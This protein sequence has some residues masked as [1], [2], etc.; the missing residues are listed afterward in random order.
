MEAQIQLQHYHQIQTFNTR[1]LNLPRHTKPRTS[2]TFSFSF[3]GLS[4]RLPE[5]VAP[6]ATSKRALESKLVI[7]EGTEEDWEMDAK[8][9]IELGF[10]EKLCGEKKGIAE[11]M[12]CLEEEAIFGSDQGRAPTDYDRRARIF[13]KSSRIFLALKQRDD[14]D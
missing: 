7:E 14:L 8:E 11:M 6:L 9:W 12:E 5:S 13:D 10:D 4:S 3:T 1:R 2:S